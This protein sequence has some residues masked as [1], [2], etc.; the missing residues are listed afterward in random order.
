MW[1]W[2]TGDDSSP[3]AVAHGSQDAANMSVADLTEQLT[4]TEQL[5]TQL[6]EL[7]REKDNELRNR[8]NRLK[9]EKEASEAKLSKV[10]LQNKAKV[11][12]LNSQLE[13][14][15]KQ[16]SGSEGQEKKAEEK[17]RVSRDGDQENAAANRGK[18]LVLRRRVEELE[19][20]NTHKNEELQKK[21]AELEAQH[22]RGAEMD[23]M[24][25]EKEKKLAEKEAYIIDLQLAC[26]SSNVAKETLAPSE[27]LKNQLSVKESSLQSMQI[28]VQN[29]TKKVGDSEERCSLLQEQ[30]E[31]LKNLQSKERDHFQEREAMYIENIRM[32]QNI[33]Q[34]KEKE[35]AG[36]AQKHEQELFKLIAKSDASADLEQL[37]KALK[38]KLHEKE[39][40]M[41]GRTQVIVMLQKELD[42]RDQ[43]L[44]EINEN[45]KRLQSEKENLQSK[46]D[47]EK[48]V[49]RAQLRDMMEKHELEMTK[50]QEKHNAEV[51][52][53][54]EKHET[55]LQ[56]KDQ[57]L[58]Q[59]Q[60]Q[61]AELRNN[62]ESNSEQS[63]DVDTV[64]KQKM[65]QLEAQVK[66]KTEEA[67]KSEAKF[68]KMKAWSK[69]KIKQLE[70]E[71]KSVHLSSKN[72]DISALK[73][74]ISELEIEKK[75]LQSKLKAFSELRIQNEELLAKLEVY[76]EQQRKLQADLE[77][78]TKRAASQA[79]E[80]GSVDEF[81]SQLLEWQEIVPESEE[82]HD[83]AREEK[84]A[85]A[86]RVAQI[87]EEREELIED[88]WFFPGCSDPAIVS[89]QQELE[90]ELTAVQRT[91][92]LQQARRKSNQASGKHQEE[93]SFDRK[94]CF[95]ELNVTL[96]STDSAEGE[97]MGG[98]WPEY[99]SPNAGLRTV[100]EELELE[101]NQLQEQILILEERC[102]DLEDRIQLQGRMEALQSEN[103]RLQTQLSQL[104][105]Q[106]MRDAEKHQVLVS[107]LNE[108]LKG[109]SD[110][111][112]FLETSLAEK[113]QKLLSTTEKLEQIEDLRQLLQEK[114]LLNKELD[115]KL[116]QTEQKL[117]EVL[118]KYN[119]YEVECTEQK[120]AINDLTEKV[121]TFKEKTLKQDAMVELMQLE[122]NQTNEEL[123]RLNTNHLEERSQLIQ[124][125]QRREREIDN[126]K[127][128]L[129][130]KDK[131]MSA[132]SSSMTEYSE[133]IVI[134]K[135][136][137]Q[138]KEEEIREMEEA[139]TKA[140][141]ETHLLKEVQTA[142]VRDTS[143]KI[144]VLSEQSNIMGL[145]L[146]KSKSQTEAKTKENEELIRQISENSI[147]I[148]DL[149]SEIKSNKVTYH[150]KLMEC[151]SQIT[152]LKEQINKTSEKLQETEAKYREETKYL[153]SQLDEN[154][155]IKE[156]L[157]S[158]L[159]EK[160]NKEQSFEK[161]LKSVKDL[162]NKL[163]L[164]AANKD[165]ELAKLSRQLAEHTEHQ[166]TVKNVLQEKLEMITSLEQK[167]QIVEQQ[168]EETKHKLIG[169]LK[170]K[171]MQFE[172]LKNHITE[173]Q[174]IVSKMEAETQTVILINK[175]LQAALEGKEKDLSE[176]IKGNEHLRN[177]ID[178]VEK[179]KQQLV[180]ENESLSKLL[181]MKECELLKR[182]KAVAEMENKVSVSETEYQKTLSE[183]NYDKEVLMKKVEQLSTLVEQKENSVTEQLLEKRKECNVLTNQLSES[184]ALTQQLHEQIQSFIIQL[185]DAKDRE[186]E[187]EEMLNNKLT[188]C[189]TL[190]QQL[191]Q[192]EEKILLLQK[193]IQDITVDFEAKEEQILHNVSLRK[194]VEEN[195]VDME[196]LQNEVRKLK[197]ANIKLSQS[198]EERDFTIKNQDVELENLHKQVAE[199]TGRSAML[200]NQVELLRKEG[201]MLKHEKE[202][203][204][205]ICS[206]KSSECADLQSQLTQHQSEIVSV[207]HQAHILN[208]ENEKLKVDIETV[209]ATVM[210]K[211]DEISSLTSHVSQQDYN[212]LALK[213]QIDSLTI[214]NEKLK[215]AVE[216]KDALLSEKEA[217]IQQMKEN[218][219]AGEGQHLKIISDL[220]N[221]VQA[222][223]SETSQLRQAA[224]EK[225]NEFKKQAQEL[226]LFKD[227]SEES[228]L[229]RFQLSENMEIISDLQCQLKNMMEKT[230]ELNQSVIQ[231]DESLKQKIDEYVNLKA[232]ISEVQESFCMQQKQLESLTSEAE[233]LKT[234]VLEKELAVSNATLVNDKLKTDLHDKER[235]CEVLRNQVTDLEEAT[236]KLKK[237]IND[238][239]KVINDISQSMLEK[240]SS[241][242]EKTSLLKKLSDRASEDEEKIQLVSQLQSQMH[243]LTQEIQK[244]KELAQEKENAF[245][246]LQEKFAAQYEQR[247]TLNVL[248]SKKEEVIAGLLNS[249]NKKDV[250]IQLAES[251]ISA[252]TNE[253]EMLREELEKSA[254]AVKSLTS[255][256]QEKDDNFAINQK[257][258]DSLT[259]E[260]DSVK[261]EHQKAQDQINIWKQDTQQKELTLHTLYMQCTEQAKNIEHLKSELNNV[262]S[263]SSQ[264]C[265]D[266]ALV[267]ERLQQQVDSLV[268]EKIL[269]Q[270]TIDK[271]IVENKELI[272]YQNQLQQKT[273]ELQEIH[274]KLE[275]TEN[276]S[277]MQIDAVKLKMKN[278]KE[279]LQMQVSVKGEE[280]SELKLK[281]EKLEQS[282][283]ESENKWVTEL[284]RAT[285]QNAI[286]KEQL[287][288][289][290][291][292]MKPKDGKIQSLQ[293]ELD[294][295]KEELTKSL[296]ALLSS[297]HFFKE[298]DAET[299][300][301]DQ[302]VSS[303][304]TKLEKF[305]AMVSTILSK[306]MEG[307]EFQLLLLEKEKEMGI[308]K[309]K[310][311][312]M[313]LIEK[314][315]ELLQNDLEKV[316]NTCQSEIECLSKEM[317]TVKDTLYKQ[318]SLGEERE[319][320]LAEMNKEVNL[321]QEKLDKSEKELQISH[322]KLNIE[323]KKIVSLLEEMEKKDHR[324]E[325][326]TSQT[327]QQNDIISALNQQ[328]KEKDCFVAQ[329]ME[330]MSNEMVK[331]SEE[332]SILNTKLQHLEA[333]Q[334]SSVENI[335]RV[336][337]QLEDCKT[338]LQHNQVK[339]STKET[340]FNDL[341]SEK[342]Q[343][344]FN[345]EKL[346]KEKEILKKKL[347]AALIIRKD[348]MQ[349]IGKLERIGQ[350]EIEKEHKKTEELLKSVDELTHQLKLVETQNK[351]LESHFET[352][353]QQ[354]FEK[355]SKINNMNESFSAKVASLEQ[356]EDSVAK[357]KDILAEKEKVS[358]QNLKS[359]QEKDSML[360]HMQSVLSEKE[361]E[362]GEER[363]HLLATLENLK[364]EIVDEEELLKDINL[365]E[366]YSGDIGN[367]SVDF[368]NEVSQPG[369]LEGDKEILQKKLQA[370]LLT[371]KENIKKLQKE[372]KEYAKLVAAFDE[373]TK[374]LER[375][376]NEHKALQEVHQRK[377]K[378][379]DCNQLLI[380]SLQKELESH[381]A[382]LQEQETID[383]NKLESDEQKYEVQDVLGE[384]EQAEF[385]MTMKDSELEKLSNDYTKL[386][387]ETKRL[388]DELRK[389]AVEL[390]EKTE[391]TVN[392]KN[393]MSQL[394]QHY[395]Q[396][397]DSLFVEIGQLQEKLGKYE[398]EVMDLKTTIE[399]MN[400]EKET[401]I[402]KSVEDYKT[403]QKESEKL[404]VDLEQ[405]NIQVAEKNGEIKELH[406]TLMDFKD[407]FDQE[408]EI[409]KEAVQLQLSLQESQKEAKH[410][411][412]AFEDMERE[413][414]E[415]INSLEKSNAEL[416]NMKKEL[417]HFSEENKELLMELSMLR[418]KTVEASEVSNTMVLCKKVKD[419]NATDKELVQ[420]HS[421]INLL[422]GRLQDRD[423]CIQ[424][425]EHDHSR[426][427]KL[428]EGTKYQIQKQ[429]KTTPEQRE[430][431]INVDE[432][433]PQE[434]KNAA[435]E[436][437]RERLQRKLQAAL[438]SR[439]EAL[440]E[441]KFLKDQVDRIMLEKEE[442]T[443]KAYTLECLLSEL[444][445]EKQ[446]SDT[447]SSLCEKETL[448]SQNARLLTENEN[449]TAACE[450]L[451]ST[452][453]T[454][455]QEKEAFSFQLNTLKDSQTVELTGWK[456]KHNELKQEYESLLQAYENISSKIAEMRQVIDVTRK[457]KQEAIHRFNERESEKHELEKQLQEV[458]NENK[459]IKDQLK[460]FA[461]SK[462]LE[463]DELQ[464]EAERQ[465][466][467]H[468]SRMEE[469]Q[470]HLHGA[471]LQNKQLMEENEQLK[472][473]SEN[474]KQALEKTENENEALHNDMNVTKL[475]LENLQV[476]MEVSQSDTQS[477]ISDVLNERESL[478]K[479]IA[480]LNDD[481]SVK[482]R[483]MHILQQERE[484]ISERVKETEESLDQK[485]NCLSKLENESR[486]LKQEIVS[487]NERVKILEDDKCLLQEELEN[488]QETSY[489][490]KNEREFLETE[491]LNHVKK[492]D[493]LTDRLK[494]AQLQNS[495]LIQQL[496]DL[497]AEKCSVIREKE[498][499]QL[500]LIKVFEEKVKCAQRDNSGTKNKTKELQELLKEKQQEV[501]QLQKDSIKFQELILDL[502]KSVKLS[503][504]KSEKF[505]KD[506]NNT[507][508]KL[509]K[510]N[511][512]IDN[513]NEK[514]SSQ[515][516]L[517]DESKSELERLAAENLS[518]KRELK[519]KEDQLQ[520][521]RREFEKELE[522]GL[523]QLKT[524]HKREWLN[525]EESRNILQREKD[526]AVSELHQL[527]EEINIKDSQNKKL[528]A[529]LNATL[530]RL[531]AFTKCMSSLQNDRDRVIGEMKTWEIQFK[532]VI[533]NKE[534]QMDDSSKKIMSLQEEM[535]DKVA[536]IQELK[537]K[538]SMLEESK[539][540]MHLWQKSVD[541]QHYSELCRIKE[542]NVTLINRQQ[543][544]E[545]A[546]QSKEAA[547]QALLKENNSLN[548]LRENSSDA[549]REIKALESNFARKEQELQQLLFEKE[550]THAELEKQIAI[551]QQM[552]EMLNNKDTEISL[553]ISSK[554][555]E[556]SG[557][558]TQIQTQHRKQ[559]NEYEQQIRSLQ[560]EREQSDEACQRMENELKN[561]QM[562]ADKAIQDKAEIASEIDAFKKSMSSLQY[563]RD[564][565]F[566]KYKDLEHHHQN[567]LSQKDSLLVNSASEN[568]ALKQELRKLLNRIDDLHSEN[569]M[570]SAQLIKYREDLNQV[571]SL[572]DHQ[573]KELLKQ[574]L[575]S[576]K[577]LEQEK[578]DL[579]KQI[580]EMQLTNKL[581]KESTESLEH[582]NQKLTSKVKALESLIASIN[583]EKL[584]SE[585]GEKPQTRGSGQHNQNKDFKASVQP[586]EKLQ[587]KF[588]E[589]QNV[590]GKN[591]KDAEDK[592]SMI[593]FEHDANF[594]WKEADASSEKR[595]LEAQFQN[596]KLKS[597]NESFGKAMTALQDDRDRL[598]EDFKVLQSKY[599]SELKSEKK[600]ADELEAD[601]NYFKS[602]LFSVLKEH[603]FLN[604]VLIDG[605]K[606]TLDQFA[607]EIENLC[608]TLITQDGEITR[609]SSECGNYV[610]Q[611][612]AFSKS[613]ASL[614]DDRD[615]LLQELSKSKAKEGASLASVEIAKLKTKVDDL[616]RALHQTKAFQ[617]ETEI[618]ISSYQ[619]EL[620]GLRMEK[621]LLLTES[622]AL[623]N[624]YQMAVAD[625]D[626]QIAELQKLQHDM[627][628]KESVSIGSNY[629]I[630]PLETVTLV[631]STN[632]PEQLKHLLAEKSQLQNELQRCLQ[633]MHQRELRFQQMNS[634]VMQ[635]VEENAVLSAQLKT[636]SQTLRENQLRYTD[637]QNRYFRFERE[638]QTV[639]VSSFQDTAQGETRAEVPPGAPQERAAVIVEIDNMELN[640]LRKRLAE[641]EQQYD[642]VQQALSQLTETLSE[643]R[644]RREAAEEAL[645]LTG[646]QCK[647]L[648]MSSYRSVPREYTVQMETEEEREALIINP[649]EHIVVRK[650]KGGALSFKRWLRGRSLYCSKLL[651]SR[652]KSR[653][654]FLTYLVTLHL[655]IFLCLT[656]IL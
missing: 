136:Q 571:L 481:I 314:E 341:I 66:L 589:V 401:V 293:Q 389:T 302:Q 32:F 24:L 582:E 387:E 143:M 568:S 588:Q 599:A 275:V 229:L 21:I 42:G 565:L 340:A 450:S 266:S 315:K 166:E 248:L 558:L 417:K 72:N 518:V 187:K 3:K 442:L 139:L 263:K 184:K 594:L 58:L 17:K 577:N 490:V 110:R 242:V 466:H 403:I 355:E 65:E 260:L 154:S 270:E 409:L 204:S 613:M 566:S 236:L 426:R 113:E 170:A 592:Y 527:Q 609:L 155:S 232:H 223:S 639:Q 125:L 147:T 546:L 358:E 255:V 520:I 308:I 78:V 515:K 380:Y 585:S 505:E 640:E 63:I 337:Q 144:S 347:Q 268:K 39:E 436:K 49:M 301:V 108:Q 177:I 44:K 258:I 511:E 356:L 102:Q 91:G 271:L 101:R 119:A 629:P 624:Q 106:Q 570:Q 498:E 419:E 536:Q 231:K 165:E 525:L 109:L 178:T 521:R 440:K 124:D 79:S 123:D 642:S 135:R 408:K 605:E 519:K 180:S 575:D 513:L 574:Q 226:K 545:I 618:Q 84:S 371:W 610:Q 398:S 534:K 449:L 312:R 502:Q 468:A 238:Q 554:G 175:Q 399:H 213:H 307:E 484:L 196:K 43:L 189:N 290:E 625:K 249:L 463:I 225:E 556:I 458:I 634:K 162:Y 477:K 381:V 544:L 247:N 614:Q 329:V 632:S 212:I 76:E 283:I 349:K 338:E 90:E 626:R 205:V 20:Q 549:G 219:V 40:V 88:D 281:I 548:H 114:D 510:S 56:E 230:A 604:P 523:E 499:Q 633:E 306:E 522:L 404:K 627:I 561:L 221:Q 514:L 182:N 438:I 142:D 28:L 134:L 361:R 388:K 368:N 597:Q 524:V 105:T 489:K 405:A 120:I 377:C 496:E 543:E 365:V 85:I 104:R 459:D 587:D 578:I 360:A 129:V 323:G 10:K 557:Y 370:S 176:Q 448:V 152:L 445:R 45:L 422:H 631:G 316:K 362:Y 276:Y 569:A 26:D 150:N 651:T 198:V 179:E 186:V 378:E 615:R 620:A 74:C 617:E 5:V 474:L 424:S 420:S 330:S 509:A 334:S 390:G 331:F 503:Q 183:L 130:E 456:A 164:E 415:F 36:Q 333:V 650:M 462:Q 296:S 47:A 305:S 14:L 441:N 82:V 643:E 319:K 418:E 529:D 447:I 560:R 382:A 469:Y 148:K 475:A 161:E 353:K 551:S 96:D 339:L 169:D 216:E 584:V 157:E 100:V 508:E 636:V 252:L 343:L 517:L 603:T 354:L 269:L 411:K 530:A 350:E 194:Q 199:N 608:K 416:L 121:A 501:N 493:Q 192:S 75:E 581:Q 188:E 149:R 167:L 35:L 528:Q 327:N 379:F 285:Q 451:K 299:S 22:Q 345:L 506:L 437:S 27:E 61:V 602:N 586:G 541:T 464:S 267:I 612:D 410:F 19:L 73:N 542:E 611:I 335:N 89:G 439:K 297:R 395:K 596:K 18:L 470:H 601:L 190:V 86:L 638:Y 567:V 537:I 414:E 31:S 375:L 195:K 336:S 168:S 112:S 69:S 209:N 95:Q 342:E 9:E 444:G 432:F 628:V 320:L 321:L 344:Q 83:Q 224:Q 201:D 413:R 287:S 486:S 540:E 317:A 254:A 485:N 51:H 11:T 480:L 304:K 324:V 203:I 126:L 218:K 397:K 2:G 630:K 562:K 159:K 653:Y 237:E 313:Q 234:I 156:K 181:D 504:S 286:L 367:N 257:K 133:Q 303:S 487:L 392:L 160:E 146:E 539:N 246:S 99:T 430:K 210:K 288:S 412:M 70:D 6:K 384:S 573:L 400:N 386:C 394:E 497:K 127:E 145:E 648:E 595:L 649:S 25:A 564:D 116:V 641:T 538:Y 273:E 235:E 516:A 250:S 579:Q 352:L 77:Q 495:L 274:E 472:H 289:L 37:L 591:T 151:E 500:H 461:E 211:S 553:L 103:E 433:Q 473:T 264:D 55:E 92:R 535:K 479:Q 243:E 644:S 309:D 208:L 616:E 8:D 600:R 531:A 12:S 421:E 62:G 434:Q 197:E 376:K 607:D 54:Q 80:S 637:L 173:R 619:N 128:V 81:Q 13:E 454:I 60:K 621:N 30:I 407:K 50:V 374:D 310:L 655:V 443:D 15:K 207:K 64:T 372:K 428:I 385:E 140:E 300:D 256:L 359:M 4:R 322:E 351:D 251:N 476:Q 325:N 656:G 373:Q 1:K 185:K 52:E 647:R 478:L 53:I 107:S 552:K 393:S 253:I 423:I 259:G 292:E 366:S 457:E 311:K 402:K 406:C 200:N 598:I 59:L 369:Q 555:G 623:R 38:Q 590:V 193:Q 291:S 453:E 526:R 295:I 158:L 153:K 494:S 48:H 262:H 278:E 138:C 482:E 455:V 452:M 220:Q 446:N 364:A 46:L 202:D 215:I 547:L 241:L 460:R 507:T 491:L 206:K 465:T 563:D 117:D 652:A 512:E 132:L 94:Q 284:D 33:I 261:H 425:L 57:A 67:S 346:V 635:S 240:E 233:Q 137:I 41:L 654:L 29:L 68:L 328:L 171:E 492:V 383:Q 93:Y 391:E 622:Q 533:Q 429:T 583:K 245:L 141:R 427:A 217:L 396:H 606:I 645:G 431:N 97:N 593:A 550:K 294:V 357:L 34:E 172:E 115:E 580:K 279:Q 71:L 572:K 348:L 646:E 122:L 282:L 332:R 228:D 244:S 318:Q 471:A 7:I 483:N 298:K 277:R 131:E 16:L 559:I 111:K 118:K 239:K 363:S 576:I 23:A 326:L 98:W 488:A 222:V 467:E 532:E 163:V 435:D 174:E 265:R 227:K 87:E 214:E 280:V 272:T 191:S